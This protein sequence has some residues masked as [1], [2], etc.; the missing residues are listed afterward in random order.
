MDTEKVKAHFIKT[1]R[2]RGLTDQ[3]ALGLESDEFFN[4]S[5]S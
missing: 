4:S 3:E 5:V 1:G 2:E